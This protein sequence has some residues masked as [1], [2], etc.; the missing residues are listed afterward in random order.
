MANVKRP[1]ARNWEAEFASGIGVGSGVKTQ[2]NFRVTP[3]G[4]LKKRGG[5]F[6]F[7]DF[8][9][10][11]RSA[12]YVE[13]EAIRG[14]YAC[15]GGRLLRYSGGVHEVGQVTERA[16]EIA[17][18]PYGDCLLVLD[19]QGLMVFDQN[20]FRKAEAYVPLVEVDADANGVG[21]A[22]ESRNLM[23][24]R[25]RKRFLPGEGLRVLPLSGYAVSV[26]RVSI[27][28]VMVSAGR[29]TAA[30]DGAGHMTV[31]LSDD[32]PTAYRE[33]EVEYT[34][35]D[36]GDTLWFGS[37][38]RGTV[39]HGGAGGSR[40]Y[41]YGGFLLPTYIC[42]SEPR[43]TAERAFY[44]PEDGLVNVAEGELMVTGLCPFM[45]QLMIFTE[46]QTRLT[47]PEKGETKS[48]I[49]FYRHPVT[50]LNDRVGHY[51]RAIPLVLDSRVIS[52]DMSGVYAW[53]HSLEP[54]LK[55]AE[56]LSGNV[57]EVLNRSFL[58]ESLMNVDYLHE[59]LLFSSRGRTVVYHYR[60]GIWYEFDG[61][62]AEGFVPTPNFLLLYDMDGRFYRFADEVKNDL[63]QPF[64]ARWESEFTDLDAPLAEKDI[65]RA[66][67]TLDEGEDGLVLVLT[68]DTGKAAYFRVTSADRPRADGAPTVLRGR[69]AMKRVFHVKA[70]IEHT[71]ADEGC[72]VQG[73]TLTCRERGEGRSAFGRIDA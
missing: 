24:N 1:P 69:A 3:D 55:N 73:L 4:K 44:F 10:Y 72:T 25:V 41:F 63:G 5:L 16:G 53:H 11:V 22:L 62:A 31:T 43:E 14:L 2:V 57:A 12:V 29:F 54:D 34:L 30:S 46:Q 35:L 6:P 61:F 7:C 18:I 8:G 66:F 47:C 26:E 32:C 36:K 64:T 23:T 38:T 68:A 13:T 21:V 60:M 40:L 56:L 45:E 48:G 59:E 50:L 19:A 17:L 52:V 9:G 67:V 27:D 58:Q 49:P 15:V 51:G 39:F 20:G 42:R 70:R 65:A 28:G 33:I 37:F 71:S